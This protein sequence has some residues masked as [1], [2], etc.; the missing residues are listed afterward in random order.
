VP[1]SL[2]KNNNQLEVVEMLALIEGIPISLATLEYITP[3][4]TY[5]VVLKIVSHHHSMFDES[6][7]I[8]CRESAE[9][10][11]K[12]DIVVFIRVD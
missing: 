9:K 6:I 1:S 5:D 8:L 12:A 11:G 2:A 4:S 3:N 10:A 7:S